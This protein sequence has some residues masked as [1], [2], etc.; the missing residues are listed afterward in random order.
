MQVIAAENPAD[1][2]TA[3][4]SR[5]CGAKTRAKTPCQRAPM[6]NGRCSKH[7]GK[8]R[9][10]GMSHPRYKHG[11]YSKCWLEVGR[12]NRIKRAE[13][14]EAGREEREALAK[15]LNDES[16]ARARGAVL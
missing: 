4:T 11:F 7:G 10:P 14:F 1:V 13:R 2:S 9:P 15:R 8:S 3:Q 6:Q 16:L 12:W 5:L